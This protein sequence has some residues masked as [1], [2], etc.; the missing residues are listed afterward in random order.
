MSGAVSKRRAR[1][2]ALAA[3]VL[4]LAAHGGA[5]ADPAARVQRYLAEQMRAQG[6]PGLALGVLRHGRPIYVQGF[7][8]ANLEWPLPVGRFLSAREPRGDEAR[9]PEPFRKHR[10]APRA[11]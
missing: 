7:G 8:A 6:I 2:A 10:R 1:G 3:L 5:P 9:L 11:V 4:P